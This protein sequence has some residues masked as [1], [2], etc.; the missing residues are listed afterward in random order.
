MV[1]INRIV[2]VIFFLITFP[3][4]LILSVASPK[5]LAIYLVWVTELVYNFLYGKSVSK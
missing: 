4:M 5:Q 1:I 2:L 3:V